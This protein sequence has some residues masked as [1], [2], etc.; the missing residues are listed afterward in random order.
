MLAIFL[1][2]LLASGRGVSARWNILVYGLLGA[3]FG[4]VIPYRH[5]LLH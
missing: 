4:V 5:V 1:A 2:L 3:L